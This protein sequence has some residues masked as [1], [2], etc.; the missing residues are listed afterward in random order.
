MANDLAYSAA[1]GKLYASVPGSVIGVGNT[2][3]VLDP[4]TGH[5][6]SSVWVGSEPNQLAMSTDGLTLYISLD[7]NKTIRTLDL[8]SL[9]PGPPF[10]MGTAITGAP[11]GVK[12]F[13]VIAGDATS[14]AVLRA[15][16]TAVVFTNGVARANTYPT[17]SYALDAIAASGSPSRLYGRSG[18]SLVRIDVTANGLFFVDQTPNLLSSSSTQLRFDS[19]RLYD[20]VGNVVD[21]E[22]RVNVGAFPTESRSMGRLVA[23]DIADGYVMFANFVAATDATLARYDP[24]TLAKTNSVSLAYVSSVTSLL[25]AGTNRFAFRTSDSVF[26]FWQE[27]LNTLAFVGSGPSGALNL[28]IGVSPVDKDGLGDGTTPMTRTYATGSGVVITAPLRAGEF[29][30]S[31]WQGSNGTSW[32]SS[33][34][35]LT[36][37]SGGTWTAIYVVP[38]PT[39]TSVSPSVGP[40][41]GGTPVTIHGA[42][43]K[44]GASVSFGGSVPTSKV[45][46]DA[47]TITAVTSA[48]VAGIVS[49]VVT[50]SNY[51][52]SSLPNAFAYRGALTFTDDPIVPGVTPVKAV[53]LTELR[54]DI[55]N[56][57]VQYGL[58]AFTWTDSSIG[59]RASRIKAA[60]LNEL[61]AALLEVY[62]TA[63]QP[64][65]TF[66]DSPLVAG[67]T[68]I[69]A[70]QFAEIRAATVALW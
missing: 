54:A 40:V 30:F 13:A 36:L 10:G 45:V 53:H 67:T 70:A 61:R 66:T 3:T 42:D 15:D 6:I 64:P 37:S 34:L 65:P 38:P 69:T 47:N 19:G 48:H 22:T 52:F 44:P 21:A 27:P 1:T 31:K 26:V 2:V 18:T 63:G 49:V 7:A 5:T 39:V 33:A 20:D 51:Q 11:Y 23:P 25:V 9:T 46:V 14:I 57:R 35:S 41:A 12:S 28:P 68:V 17:T 16:R 50:N 62:T 58:A 60:H 4:A 43:F 24:T 59:A 8:S 55:A 56:L 32:S 29:K